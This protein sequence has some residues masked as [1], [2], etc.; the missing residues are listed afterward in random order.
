MGKQRKEP[1][2]GGCRGPKSQAD[3]V[4]VENA[5]FCVFFSIDLFWQIKVLMGGV[6]GFCQKFPACLESKF[7]IEKNNKIKIKSRG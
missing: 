7:F 1:S 6:R 4:V 2:I 3:D 5:R